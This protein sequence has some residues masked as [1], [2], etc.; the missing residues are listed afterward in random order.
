MRAV[1]AGR[2][3]LQQDLAPRAGI[4]ERTVGER[5]LGTDQLETRADL[6]L[7]R[8]AVASEPGVDLAQRPLGGGRLAAAETR[9]REQDRPERLAEPVPGIL[10]A[11]DGV[12]ADLGRGRER[13]RLG[14]QPGALQAKDR[15]PQRMVVALGEL[16]L[17]VQP[18]NSPAEPTRS[19]MRRSRPRRSRMA[20][21]GTR[22]SLSG[23]RASKDRPRVRSSTAS[24]LAERCAAFSAATRRYL[25]ACA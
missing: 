24:L 11:G 6:P 17:L 19:P 21:A 20:S 1:S 23:R 10:A 9:H 4:V 8:E 15:R 7:D 16:D 5:D 18:A 13:E 3:K 22:R 14:A 25:T 12:A 2:R